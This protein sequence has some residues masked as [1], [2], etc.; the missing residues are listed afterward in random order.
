MSVCSAKILILGI[1][2]S[3]LI[4]A[5]IS[6][7]VGE[8]AALTDSSSQT[9]CTHYNFAGTRLENLC[10]RVY[11]SEGQKHVINLTQLY[12]LA[13]ALGGEKGRDFFFFFL[14]K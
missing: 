5:I 9:K 8:K 12:V 2:A 3:I 7:S 1:L 13:H 14:N 11:F 10:P 4:T 6:H